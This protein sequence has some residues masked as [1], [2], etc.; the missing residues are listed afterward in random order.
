[1]AELLARMG[2]VEQAEAL[3]RSTLGVID[4]R[5]AAQ[6]SMRAAAQRALAYLHLA[7]GRLDEARS[8]MDA[9]V[10]LYAGLGPAGEA[11]IR[12]MA[13]LRAALPEG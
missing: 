11:Q 8:A 3:I 10:T 5:Y 1:M 12:L 4:E 13:P 7:R 2:L 9:A 6:P